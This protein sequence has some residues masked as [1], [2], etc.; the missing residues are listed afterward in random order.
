MKLPL[1]ITYRD[2]ESSP[3]ISDHVRRHSEK[4]DTFCD[5]I[6]SCRVALEAPNR[7][8]HKG[9]QYRVRLDVKVPNKELVAIH[10]PMPDARIASD[11]YLVI[12]VAF[13]K[14][15]REVEAYNRMSR[16]EVKRHSGTPHGR[17]SKL[18]F[19]RGYGFI[20]GTDGRE[21]YFHQ[22]SVLR[23]RFQ[24]LRIG[25]EVRFAEEAGDKGPQASTV[26]VVGP[27]REELFSTD[28]IERPSYV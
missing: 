19:D 20:E 4:L 7:Y 3:A 25:S 15:I 5:R 12:D 16:W 2:I 23:H 24:A 21:I 10:A 27:P 11:L 22:N 6:M 28:Q 18:F 9:K 1:Q 17:V 26:E 14:M 13:A 8:T